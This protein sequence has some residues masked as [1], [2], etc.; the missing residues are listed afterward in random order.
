[1]TLSI[2]FWVPSAVMLRVIMLSVAFL[3]GYDVCHYADCLYDECRYA[4]CRYAECHGAL[5]CCFLLEPILYIFFC[6]FDHSSCK[7]HLFSAI[8]FF[9][10]KGSI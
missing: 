8:N 6:K 4:E 7:L 10:M 5:K 3:Y 2:T 9:S 1:M